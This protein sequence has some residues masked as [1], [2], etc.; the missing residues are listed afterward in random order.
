MF[1]F[2]L[3]LFLSASIVTTMAARVTNEQK[4]PAQVQAEEVQREAPRI[5]DG[6]HAIAR[7]LEA[8]TRDHEAMPDNPGA[9]APAYTFWP[10]DRGEATWSFGEGSGPNGENAWICLS[11]IVSEKTAR[12]M[13]YAERKFKE[14]N[15]FLAGECAALE[16]NQATPAWPQMRAAS[17]W[18]TLPALV[19]T[20]T[21][22]HVTAFSDCW[23]CASSGIGT[24]PGQVM[25]CSS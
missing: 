18:V 22:K 3:A 16:R 2:A 21:T 4:P 13:T 12:A 20:P 6:F 9:L 23:V 1:A 15:Y 8:Y 7:G 24:K 5:R 17:Y 14:G 19:P 10:H 11:G 25:R